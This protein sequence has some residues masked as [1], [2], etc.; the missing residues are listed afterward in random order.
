MIKKKV[1]WKIV[2]AGLV[3]LTVIELFALSK[4]ING[5][6]LSMYIAIV[7]GAIGYTLPQPK[8]INN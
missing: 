3:C 6:I 1:D 5:T 2:V 7:A 8:F 4:G